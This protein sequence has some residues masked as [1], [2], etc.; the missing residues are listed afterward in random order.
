MSSYAPL[1]P[2]PQAKKPPKTLP[3]NP[4]DRG[5]ARQP[6]TV[7][8]QGIPLRSLVPAAP[9]DAPVYTSRDSGLG[10]GAVSK[11]REVYLGPRAE[12]LAPRE[13][14]AMLAHEAVHVAQQA[15]GRRTGTR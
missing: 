10:A 9:V 12:A 11:G 15:G 3:S 4:M 14:N 1:L 2:R 8:A 6:P 5:F 13:L 7:P